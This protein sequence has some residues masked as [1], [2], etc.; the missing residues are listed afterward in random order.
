MNQD[1][2]VQSRIMK[3]FDNLPASQRQVAEY[4]V[5]DSA[6][7]PYMT[8]QNLADASNS[9]KSAV[10]RFI[11][12]L[13]Y[14]GYPDFRLAVRQGIALTRMPIE[15]IKASLS[16]EVSPEQAFTAATA[17]AADFVGDIANANPGSQIQAV[18]TELLNART[19]KIVGSGFSTALV[20]IADFH[21]SMALRNTVP[22]T[23]GDFSSLIRKIF[24]IDERDV[25]FMITFP[26]YAAQIIEL[27]KFAQSRGA[28]IIGL[29]DAPSSPLS[30][31]VDYPLLA[32]SGRQSGI[33][34]LAAPVALIEA[35]AFLLVKE[36]KISVDAFEMLAER[37][38]PN[39]PE[40]PTSDDA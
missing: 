26:P 11:R 30:K 5:L 8:I 9:S 34:S 12:T 15:Q 20:Q 24:H 39:S 1:T 31:I 16:T 13:G 38:M 3:V 6:N 40:A 23:T 19:V 18:V 21:F 4:V 36:S 35:L 14:R 25:V 28:I 7:V 29:T 17:E 10:E 2:S 22:L 27:A 33:N 32:K 37:L